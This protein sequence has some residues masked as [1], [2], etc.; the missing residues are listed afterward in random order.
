MKQE[1][2]VKLKTAE[3]EN[4]QRLQKAREQ[5]QELLKQA[6]VRADQVLRSVQTEAAQDQQAQ[7]GAERSRLET[8]RERILAEGRSREE[9]LRASYAAHVA[10][11]VKK[12]LEVFE[13]SLHV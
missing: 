3:A 12:A 13:R 6:R 11:R 1:I 8:E 9:K 5:A 4:E 2:L 10:T 7:L